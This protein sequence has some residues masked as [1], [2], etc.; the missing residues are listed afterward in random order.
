MS[1]IGMFKRLIFGASAEPREQIQSNKT[2]RNEYAFSERDKLV[3]QKCAADALR[4]FT[5]SLNIA[6]NSKNLSTRESRLQIARNTLIELKKMEKQF[7]FLHLE[8]LQAVEASIAGVE[9]ETR[10]LSRAQNASSPAG[11]TV[12]ELQSEPLSAW[13]NDDIAKGLRFIATLQ[14]RTPLRVLL[15]DGE[16]HRDIN[17][18]PPKYAREMWEGIWVTKTKTFHEM[19]IDLPEWP[20]SE[21]AS[22]IG[23]VLRREYLPFLK[24]VREIVELDEPIEKRIEKLHDISKVDKWK[25][26]IERHG[27]IEKIIRYFFAEFVNR[28]PKAIQEILESNISI[29]NRIVK[30]REM[31]VAGEWKLYLD[32]HYG[33]DAVIDSFFPKFIDTIPKLSLSQKDELSKMSLI[34]PNLIAAVPD[35][36]LLSIKGIGKA[37]LKTIRDYCAGIRDNRDADRVEYVIK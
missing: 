30:L 8:N 10:E 21:S 27:G 28:I 15:R 16:I 17:T 26:Y 29:E 6:N 2:F 18:A 34:T 35:K 22:D 1:I 13:G 25:S 24:A 12:G 31:P 11:K 20:E 9:A 7:P 14:L 5:E 33:I 4:V 23:Y 37:K 3:A 19:G 36:T 32:N